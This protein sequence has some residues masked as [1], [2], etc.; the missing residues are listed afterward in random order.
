MEDGAALKV[1]LDLLHDV[2]EDFG[3]P[4]ALGWVARQKYQAARVLS[5]SRERETILL[6]DLLQ[7]GVRH[8]NEHTGTVSGVDLA[9]A[10]ATMVEVQKNLEGVFDD[11]VGFLPLHVDQKSHPARVML[12]LRVV[13][14]HRL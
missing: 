5:L 3:E 1:A 6:R 10:R 13:H 11:G 12:E 9:T 14:C 2:L 8:L 4:P 7:E